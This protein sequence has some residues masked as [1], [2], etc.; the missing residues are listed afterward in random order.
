MVYI[1]PVPAPKD[2]VRPAGKTD[3][4]CDLA[5]THAFLLPA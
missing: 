3:A 2:A 4:P 5:Q 1:A